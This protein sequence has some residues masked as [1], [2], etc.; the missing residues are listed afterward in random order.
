MIIIIYLLVFNLDL[1]TQIIILP[2]SENLGEESFITLLHHWQMQFLPGSENVRMGGDNHTMGIQMQVTGALH[3]GSSL[4]C[5]C[6][7]S[8]R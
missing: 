2:T 3:W 8:W 6:D 4:L 5:F 7:N 1:Y